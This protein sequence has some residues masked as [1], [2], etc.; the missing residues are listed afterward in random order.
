MSP[1]PSWEGH[2]RLS[3]VS[4]PV[5]L[6]GAT[7]RAGSVSFHLINPA[8]GHRIRQLVVDAETGEEVERRDLVRGYETEKDE[9]LLFTDE[10]IASVRPESTRTID[11][12]RFVKREAIDRIWWDEPYYLAP[13]EKSGVEAFI[14]I[15]EALR[16]SSQVAIGRVV[17]HMRER[18][19]AIEPRGNG[20]LVTT[21]RSHDDLRPESEVF[22]SIP[23][24]RADAKMV[25]IADRI[26]AQQA[27]PFEPESFVDQYEEGL[28]ELIRRKQKGGGGGS[29]AP[30]PRRDNV[31][32]LMDALK[33]SLSG[34]KKSGT[35]AKAQRSKA[36]APAAKKATA[37]T[38]RRRTTRR[39]AG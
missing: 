30:A 6:Y 13:S 11:I 21:L 35:T 32:D 12:E 36:S 4:C 9:Y 8:T 34:G 16:R 31:I 18:M 37:K 39:K 27:A 20:I 33:R 1:R 7:T 23:S 14:V 22:D 25:D 19:V 28:R 38:P 29:P 24:H 26:I 17:L 5:A 10:E 2:L 3:L 15:R